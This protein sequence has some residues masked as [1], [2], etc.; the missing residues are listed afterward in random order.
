MASECVYRRHNGK[1]GGLSVILDVH[2]N[3]A[4]G[5]DVEDFVR[6]HGELFAAERMKTEERPVN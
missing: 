3:G 5:T 4:P 1:R 2:H 6:V